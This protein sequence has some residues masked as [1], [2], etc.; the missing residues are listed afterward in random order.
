MAA[1][2]KFLRRVNIRK[3]YCLN[4]WVILVEDK[5]VIYFS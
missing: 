4:L 2:K 5:V 1:A 3:R